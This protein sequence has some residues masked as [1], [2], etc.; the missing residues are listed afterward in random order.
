MGLLIDGVGLVELWWWLSFL[1]IFLFSGGCGF[2]MVVGVVGFMTNVVVGDWWWWRW[3][4]QCWLWGWVSLCLLLFC[5]SG[6]WWWWSD[7]VVVGMGD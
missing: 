6:S 2:L 5:G 4:L 1:F 7:V 3:G